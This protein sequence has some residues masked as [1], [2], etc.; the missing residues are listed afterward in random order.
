MR[1]FLRIFSILVVFLATF[2]L[3]AFQLSGCNVTPVDSQLD[4]QPENKPYQLVLNR[5]QQFRNNTDGVLSFVMCDIDGDGVKEHVEGNTQKLL[6]Y[7]NEGEGRILPRWEA[8]L[9]DGFFIGD[10]GAP[11]GA[12][13]DF[14]GDKVEEIYFS[15]FSK[16]RQEWRF[17]AFDPATSQFFLNTPLPLGEDRRR[18]ANWD[19]SYL[20]VGFLADADGAGG[21]GVVL[22]RTAGY[23]A[24]LRGIC[25]VSPTTGQIIWE[26]I[27]GAQPIPKGIVVDD[28]DGDGNREICWVT[29]APDNLGGS[30]INGTTDNQSYLIVLSHLGQP[31]M[32]EKLSSRFSG[33]EILTQ[34]LDGDDIS[35]L[36]TCTTNGSTGGN[37]QLSV[38]NWSEQQ[39][40]ATTR[41]VPFFKGLAIVPGSKPGTHWIITGSDNGSLARYLYADGHLS[42][43]RQVLQDM[44]L[45]M[46]LGQGDFLPDQGPEIFVNVGLAG[47]L[48]VVNSDLEPLAIYPGSDYRTK[49]QVN[50][51]QRR[52]DQVS[53]VAGYNRGQWVFD[54]E[55]N[56]KR[57][58]ALAVKVG[59]ALILVLALLGMFLLGRS[60][61]RLEQGPAGSPAIAQAQ[62]N[63]QAM[64]LLHRELADI[65]HQVVGKAKGLARLIWL[66]EA[67]S[68]EMGPSEELKQRIG[69]VL[70][71]FKESVNPILA[72]ILKQ[73]EEASFELESVRATS[74]VLVTLARRIDFLVEGQLDPSQIAIAREDLRNEWTQVQEGFLHLRSTIND[75]FTTDPARMI[76]GM[77]LVRTE[78]LE[79]AGITAEFIGPDKTQ[80]T[81]LT[82]ID[83]GDL[84]FVLD[85]LL[86][87][88]LN[89]MREADP[90]NL[91]VLLT[92]Q[93]Q[94]IALHITDNG[95]GIGPSLHEEIFS[96][97]FSS[98]RG[99]GHGLFRS[100]EILRRWGGEIILADSRPGK[101]TTF[102]V[103]LLAADR[104]HATLAREAR[105]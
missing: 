7:D 36:I 6:G 101:G 51:W 83:S 88:A 22:M 50:L 27:S 10:Q 53:L 68:S 57:M 89:A 55:K 73:A 43:D 16:D 3:A 105:G 74:Q 17:V 96:G 38:W 2:A 94:E 12:C 98:H 63:R 39:V 84:R 86:D 4:L 20:A 87:N 1:N 41:R 24:T 102:I 70:L 58:N 28:L 25:V 97:R 79:R 34:D 45:V 76:E 52:P 62:A 32:T 42:L 9:E 91:L 104:N 69:Q 46:V 8:H 18:P 60:K 67:Y 35:E 64:F 54:Y 61:G 95:K 92:V 11:F 13:H 5:G 77:I 59:L 66:L 31:L 71:D 93:D 81:Y 65:N 72:S 99:G 26:Y 48:V 33:G 21:P 15:V 75:Y 103:K 100:R 44:D 82:Q 37:S 30:L 19:G 40:I 90:G 80:A 78:E 49:S 56:P 85:N 47:H 14:N 23:D 29:S